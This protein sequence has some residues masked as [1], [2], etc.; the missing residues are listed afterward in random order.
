MVTDVRNREKIC[1]IPS[2]ESL[3]LLFLDASRRSSAFRRL[4]I[5]SV[6]IRVSSVLL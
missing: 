5:C 1:R 3:F 6:V 2:F 4:V